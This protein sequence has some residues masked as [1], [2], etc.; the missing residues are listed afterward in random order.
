VIPSASP[1]WTP[2]RISGTKTKA[3]AIRE[4]AVVGSTAGYDS[5]VGGE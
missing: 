1:I 2:A 4:S 5:S 3:A